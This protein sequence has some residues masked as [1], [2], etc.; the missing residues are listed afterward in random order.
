MAAAEAASLR[1][2]Q[3]V[4]RDANGRLFTGGYNV[5]RCDDICEGRLGGK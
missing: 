3:P 1:R 5:I 2:D 4:N